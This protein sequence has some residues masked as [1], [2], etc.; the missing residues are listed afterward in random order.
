M[1][2]FSNLVSFLWLRS[3][4]TSNYQ[5][6]CHISTLDLHRWGCIDWH[7]HD[8]RF[9]FIF[10]KQQYL[11]SSP[12]QNQLRHLF[13]IIIFF[14]SSF[15]CCNFFFVLNKDENQFTLEYRSVHWVER[16]FDIITSKWFVQKM[17]RVCC[18]EIYVLIFYSPII[19][20]LRKRLFLYRVTRAPLNSSCSLK[21]V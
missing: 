4:D 13:E 19:Y 21:V 5:L 6:R 20:L 8:W 10:Y 7:L 14:P 15:D 11:K 17:K 2:K 3:V 9:Q 18:L 12:Y 16:Y 1:V